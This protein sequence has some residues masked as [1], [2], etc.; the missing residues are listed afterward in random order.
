MLFVVSNVFYVFVVGAGSA[1]CGG[2]DGGDGGNVHQP[3][4]SVADRHCFI[5]SF[6]IVY[7]WYDSLQILCRIYSQPETITH[8]F[9][10]VITYII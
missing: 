3:I 5:Y 6:I 8:P 4:W 9:W 2:G 10:L 1:G 7:D